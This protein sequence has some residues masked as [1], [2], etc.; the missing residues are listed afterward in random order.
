[1][2][3]T[4]KA[5]AKGTFAT[6]AAGAMALT[7]ASPAAAQDRYRDRHDNGISAGEVIAGAVILGGLAAILSSSNNDR[8]DDRHYGDRNYRDNRRGYGANNGRQA[9][10]RCVRAAERQA[11]R[12]SG[13]RAEVYEIRDVDRE[14][15]GFEVKG[16]IAVRDNHRSRN[17]RGDYRR[18]GRNNGWDEGRFKCDYRNGRVV[19]ID[20]S[21]I[22]GL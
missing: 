6:V 13:S 2:K 4:T 21:G 15:R 9:V 1:M 5:L 3:S 16:R 22:R 7:A 12:W 17:Y 14:R 20:F 11:Q 10:E 8:Y 18:G 19:D